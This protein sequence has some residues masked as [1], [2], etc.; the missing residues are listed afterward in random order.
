MRFVDLA[1]IDPPAGLPVTVQEFI[2]HARL[3][4]ITVDRQPDL[5]ER[6]LAA[7]TARCEQFLRRSVITQTLKAVYVPDGLGCACT[8]MLKLPRGKVQS[9][10]S[11]T[12]NGNELPAS[13]YKFD[14]DL[15]VLTLQSP[16]T[17]AVAV[18]FLSGY[19]ATPDDVPAS[20][21][22]GILEYACTLYEDRPGERAAKYET[23]SRGIP[24][25]VRDLW[26]SEQIEL[27]G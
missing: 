9:V 27:S 13:G 11:V 8:L 3:N 21:K 1:V 18:T 14:P 23:S 6:E 10:E 12:S 19:G 20:V 16:A 25:G 4:G 22:E 17:G 24:P 2:D 26:R 7:A 5:V 15:G